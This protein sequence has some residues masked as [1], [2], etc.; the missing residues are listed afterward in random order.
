M[1]GKLRSYYEVLGLPPTATEQDI[2]AA[3][4]SLAVRYHPDTS[5]DA[6]HSVEEFKNITEAHEILSDRQKRC[7]YDQELRVARNKR[8]AEH[9]DGGS[10]ALPVTPEEARHGA[11]V[12]VKFKTRR[13]CLQCSVEAA[14]GTSL[15]RACKG[16]GVIYQSGSARVRVP[17]GA[18]D[19]STLLYRDAALFDRPIAIH[20]QIRAAW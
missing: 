12:Q 8:R 2:S 17:A 16:V 20:I 9:F 14:R 13:P 6:A 10:L 5:Q 3:Y 19:G 15:C 7:R 1:T 4:R 11:T 18:V